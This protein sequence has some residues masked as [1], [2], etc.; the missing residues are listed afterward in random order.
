[1]RQ[2]HLGRDLPQLS[3]N[4]SAD[5]GLHQ[6]AGDQRDRLANEILKPTIHRLGDDIGNRHPLTFGHRGA[7]LHVGLLEQPDE[8]GAAVADP[9][10]GRPT[11]RSLHHFYRRDL[12][13]T[14]SA[15]QNP[16]PEEG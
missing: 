13:S 1:M 11:R 14:T 7:L 12:A 8:F 6:L 15:S 16:L 9:R 5:L 3:T 10:S 2:P 4:L